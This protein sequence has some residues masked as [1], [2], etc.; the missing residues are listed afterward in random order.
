MV[1]V[2][3]VDISIDV[4][5]VQDVN[6]LLSLS[7]FADDYSVIQLTAAAAASFAYFS[8]CCRLLPAVSFRTHSL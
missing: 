5:P 3:V 8:C 7:L 4:C 2:V 1:V 6:T